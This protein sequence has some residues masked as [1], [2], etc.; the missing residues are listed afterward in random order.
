MQ[1]PPR[2]YFVHSYHVICA[3]S[4]DVL[5]WAHHGYEFVAGF[6]KANITGVQFH[7]ERATGCTEFLRNW[8]E[9]SDGH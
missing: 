3:Q 6:A 7:P 5:V 9:A 1:R 4:E 2:F 8:V